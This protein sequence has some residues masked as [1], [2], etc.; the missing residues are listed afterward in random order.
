MV[1]IKTRR[2]LSA[3]R[4]RRRWANR[5]R[6]RRARL[7]PIRILTLHFFRSLERVAPE[8][9]AALQAEMNTYGVTIDV[10]ETDRSFYFFA[11]PPTGKILAGTRALGRLWATGYGYFCLYTKVAAAKRANLAIREIEFDREPR[12]AIAATLLS[13]TVHTEMMLAEA[14]KAKRS[15]PPVLWP[16]DLPRPRKSV[17]YA[18]DGHVADELF[19]CAAAYILHHE[20]AHFRCKHKRSLFPDE[21]RDMEREADVEAAKWLLDGLNMADPRFQKRALGIALALGWM[22]SIARYVPE[23]QEHHPPSHERLAIVIGQFVHDPNDAIWAFVS[24]LLRANLEAA[25]I[26][27]NKDREATSFKDDVDYCLSLFAK[28]QPKKP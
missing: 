11:D 24:T 17:P 10:I 6:R 27:Y 15:L 16:A 8:K 5:A 25:K 19:L 28:H 26:A 21:N 23:D 2:K 13:W 14:K 22:A 20:L 12:T 1:A 18:T 3:K 9:A 7:W 4:R